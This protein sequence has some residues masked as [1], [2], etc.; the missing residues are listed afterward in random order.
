MKK[1][2]NIIEDLHK[3]IDINELVKK[4]EK[5]NES[6]TGNGENEKNRK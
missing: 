3:G 1:Q 2:I 4:G 5:K 6:R